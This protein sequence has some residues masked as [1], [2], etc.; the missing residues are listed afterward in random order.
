MITILTI[1]HYD[2]RLMGICVSASLMGVF[3]GKFLEALLACTPFLVLV[4]K[5]KPMQ[6]HHCSPFFWEHVHVCL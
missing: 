3:D 2:I 1:L 5:I 4:G 6:P